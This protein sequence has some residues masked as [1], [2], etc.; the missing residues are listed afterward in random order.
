MEYNIDSPT[1]FAAA[2][3]ESLDLHF[4]LIICNIYYSSSVCDN[5]YLNI[6]KIIYNIIFMLNL[7]LLV[8]VYNVDVYIMYKAIKIGLKID[9]PNPDMITNFLKG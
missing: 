4:K 8:T 6:G 2:N 1:M 3:D 7:C 5:T 9:I